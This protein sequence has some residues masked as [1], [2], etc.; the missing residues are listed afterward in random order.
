MTER[1]AARTRAAKVVSEISNRVHRELHSGRGNVGLTMH[2]T[3]PAAV[4]E[5]L[6][7]MCKIYADEIVNLSD[8]ALRDELKTEI[9]E[10][11]NSFIT[12]TV[13]GIRGE[14]SAGA[15]RTASNLHSSVSMGIH[16]AFE[17]A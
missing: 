3:M 14:A 10:R 4:N 13:A 11:V 2:N 15:A 5:M 7:G 1:E 9:A 8:A 12:S 6:E 17:L 16:S